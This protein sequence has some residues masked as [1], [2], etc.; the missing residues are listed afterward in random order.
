MHLKQIEFIGFKSF[1]QKTVLDFPGGIAAIVGPNGSGKSNIIDGIRWI[2]GERE[3]KNLRGGKAE[4][5]IFAGTPKRSRMGMAQVTITFDNSSGF[6]PVDFPEVTI[7][8]RI[9]RDGLSQYFL[10]KTEVRL[11]DIIDFF[12]QSRLGTRGL[13]IVN[14]GN[15]DLFVKASPEERREMVEEILGLRQY[16]LKKQEADRKLKNTTINLEKVKAMLEELGPHLRFLKRQTAKW[17]KVG[18]VE[19]ELREL[20]KVYFV[21]KLRELEDGQKSYDPELHRIEGLIVEKQ[22]ELRELEKALR[23]IETAKPK[24]GSSGELRVQRDQLLQERFQIEKE[25]S[26]IEAKLELLHS[27][28]AQE[29]LDLRAGE[30]MVILEDVKESLHRLLKDRNIDNVYAE[31]ETLLIKIKKATERSSKQKDELQELKIL[32]ETLLKKLGPVSEALKQVSQHEEQSVNEFQ[33]FNEDFRQA[34][35]KLEKKKD[36]IVELEN[37]KNKIVFEIER[38]NYRRQDLELQMS[39]VSRK[40]SE[41]EPHIREYTLI[42]VPELAE[43]E[44]KMLR[45]R[46]E[47]A[48]IG[49]VDQALIK[50]AQDTEQRHQFLSGQLQDLEKAT[51]DLRHLIEELDLKIH[52]DFTTALHAI[53]EEFQKFFELM[54]GGGKAKMKLEKPQKPEIPGTMGEESEV[55]TLEVETEE[56]LQAGIELE[57]SLPRKKI[58]GLEMLSGGEKSLVSIAALFALISVSPPPFLV[59]DEVDA[60][61]DERN[62][63]RFAELIKNFSRKTQFVLVTHNRAT[64]EAASVL[65]G[66]TMEEDGVSKVLSLKLEG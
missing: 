47:L 32:K 14:Q 46:S 5:L 11:R 34:F 58:K 30:L 36:E 6:F 53:N 66:V 26:R 15:S 28:A 18:D 40:V 1:A 60:A 24:A 61:L 9:D 59:L 38:L 65:Y 31:V 62:T 23:A 7:I 50:E 41:F 52:H 13:S 12:A 39:H 54:F 64:M 21:Q 48:G 3:A 45:L 42:G 17:E 55:K 49:E 20:E 10:N 57:V 22:K 19:K 33:H 25:V 44:R 56:D 43:V 37:A 4:D 16:Q 35:E 8:R 2:L 51:E 63:K 29:N 27:L